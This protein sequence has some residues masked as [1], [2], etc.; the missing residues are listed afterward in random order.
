[1]KRTSKHEECKI[2]AKNFAYK[3]GLVVKLVH[4]YIRAISIVCCEY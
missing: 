4:K 2:D 3:R 1:M